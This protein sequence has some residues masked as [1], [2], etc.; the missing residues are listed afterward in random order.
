MQANRIAFTGYSRS[1]KDT[2]AE[3]LIAGGYVRKCFGDIIK[4]QLDGLIRLHFGF[5]A[6]T[7]KDEEK[8]KIRPLLELWGETNYENIF[9]QFF[10]SLPWKCVNTRLCRV[11]EGERW[12][13]EG[14][15][16]I[17]IVRPGLAPATRWELREMNKLRPLVWARVLNDGTPE[18]LHREISNLFELRDCG[19]PAHL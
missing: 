10:A 5:S 19:N 6:F 3:P 15:V 1:G 12:I 18:D 4:Q 8:K 17:E 9:N 14:G 11:P 16:I 7:E 13:K 2:A